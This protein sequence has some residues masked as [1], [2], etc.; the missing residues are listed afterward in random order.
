MLFNSEIFI[1]IFLPVA[2]VGFYILGKHCDSVNYSKWYLVIASLFFYG[3]WNIDYVPFL[4]ISVAINFYLGNATRLARKNKQLLLI[5]GIVINLSFLGYFKYFNFFID[6]LNILF[7]GDYFVENIIL[8]LAISFYTFQQIGYLL[9]SYKGK[10]RQES[11]LN[12]S[13]FVVFFPQLIAGPIVIYREIF[14]QFK[15]STFGKFKNTDLIVGLT[16]FFIGLFKKVVIADNLSD[17]STPVFT[18]AEAGGELD[19]LL[20]WQGAFSYT[21]QLYFDFSGYSDMAIG[22]G[23]MFGLKLPMNFYSPFKSTSIIDFWRRWH[24]TL[25]RFIATDLFIPLSAKYTRIA[26]SK[27]YKTLAYFLV[28]SVLPTMVTFVLVGLW[29]GAGWTFIF[30]GFMHGIYMIVNYAWRNLQAAKRKNYLPPFLSW[31]ITFI[32]II[33]SFVIFRA[34]SLESGFVVLKYMF[35][36]DFS[37]LILG[38]SGFLQNLLNIKHWVL[39]HMYGYEQYIAMATFVVFAMPNTMQLMSRYNPCIDINGIRFSSLRSILNWRAS[40][41]W[42]SFSLIVSVIALLNTTGTT[43]FLY[44]QF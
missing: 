29:H 14:P 23:R 38:M 7:K 26:I 24:A 18:I 35:Q 2:F 9:D 4:I 25:G 34:D 42:V 37:L 17:F 15:K 22:L 16:I 19:F 27:R 6:N 43:E 12:Y 28:A 5:I 8:P 21:F 31:S 41:L 20:A 11:F 39:F 40:Y 13:L 36:P 10:T 44:F 30:F 3:W 1:F 32:C 33:V